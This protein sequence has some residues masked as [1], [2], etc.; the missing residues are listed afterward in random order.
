MPRSSQMRKKDQ[1][2][3]RALHGKI[4]LGLGEIGI[5]QGQI[6]RQRIAPVFDFFEKRRVNFG[7]AFLGL[8]GFGVFVK[9]AFENRVF[10]ENIA[11]LFPLLFVIGV[12]QI[13][14]PA[15]GGLVGLRRLLAA[16]INGKFFK[17][18]ENTERQFGR[19]GITAQFKRRADVVF[20][21]DR[22][23]FRLHKK[24]ARPADTKAIIR[25]FGVAADFDGV[26]VNH[27]FVRLGVALLVVNVPTQ[28]S[29]EGIDELA[30]K[31][32]FIVI[33]GEISLAIALKALDQSGDFVHRCF[34]TV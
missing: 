31:L 12:T 16:I 6:A 34:K 21:I 26:F 17:I 19:P 1:A 27:V 10:R 3:N 32:G 25:R 14:R 28:R 7:G 30:A 13:K 29:K 4:Q 15:G 20:E 33:A 2:V 18:G 8:V 23:L 11:D 22:G 5:A 24:F 9:R